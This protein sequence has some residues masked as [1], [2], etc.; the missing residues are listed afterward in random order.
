MAPLAL[1]RLLGAA[2]V[3]HVVAIGREAALAVGLALALA[4]AAAAG[5][6]RLALFPRPRRRNAR[7]LARAAARA[8]ARVEDLLLPPGR[9]PLFSMV[10]R[11]LV[12]F[13]NSK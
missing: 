2:R 7:E 1:H 3:L 10:K 5:R 13:C 6:A 8:E 12:P 9:R 11:G 4:A